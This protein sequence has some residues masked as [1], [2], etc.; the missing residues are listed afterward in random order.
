MTPGWALH[1]SHTS[2]WVVRNMNS[3]P[4]VIHNKKLFREWCGRHAPE[5]V[6]TKGGNLK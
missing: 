2:E 1:Q 5:T 6:F 3:V 4:S